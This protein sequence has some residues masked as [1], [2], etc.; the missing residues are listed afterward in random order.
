[1]YAA[2]YIAKVASTK[3]SNITHQL[4]YYKSSYKAVGIILTVGSGPSRIS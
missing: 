1:M 2:S 3:L 4:V